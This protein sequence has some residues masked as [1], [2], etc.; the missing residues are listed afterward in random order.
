MSHVEP[1]IRPPQP[2]R[3]R[4]NLTV[5]WLMILGALT[6]VAGSYYLQSRHPALPDA[7]PMHVSSV[8]LRIIGRYVAGYHLVLSRLGVKSDEADRKLIE[9]VEQQ[10]SGEVE[11]LRTVT[12]VGDMLGPQAA[13]QR[14]D[15]LEPKLTDRRL[16]AEAQILRSIYENGD[17]DISSEDR[18][19]LIR[20]H[21]W[22]AKLVLAN[23][24]P[25]SSTEWKAAYVPAIR[26]VGREVGVV[27]VAL[28]LFVAGAVLFVLAMLRLKDG[29]L[30]LLYRPASYRTDPFLEAFAV[31]LGGFIVLP[32][33]LRRLLPGISV[34]VLMATAVLPVALA[35][36]WPLLRG[37]GVAASREGLGLY[38]GGRALREMARE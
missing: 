26:H 38:G 8:R 20:R 17:E 10:A 1:P 22:F 16:K 3:A 9:Q 4:V 11:A 28:G 31:Y 33:L 29:R 6:Y 30:R 36:I 35:M 25:S 15:E 14:L 37:A 34:I 23:G 24:R 12:I 13:V 2:R 18:E 7:D 19:A 21:G 27:V 32:L 5:A